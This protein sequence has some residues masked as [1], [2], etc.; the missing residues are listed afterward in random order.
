VY[1]GIPEEYAQDFKEIIFTER[2]LREKAKELA[3][4]ISN[5]VPVGEE[6]IIVGLLKGAFQVVTDVAR[7]LTVPNT[8]EFMIVSSYGNETKVSQPL[9]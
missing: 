6:V 5:D 1:A 8:V 9:R 4:A 2:V 7:Y 3:I